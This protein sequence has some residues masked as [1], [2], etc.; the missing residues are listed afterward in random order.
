MYTSYYG[1]TKVRVHITTEL[2]KYKSTVCG[3][4]VYKAAWPWQE[5]LLLQR[6]SFHDNF[7]IA[8]YAPRTAILSVMY[9]TTE[10]SKT[11]L[12]FLQKSGSN[13]T[14]IAM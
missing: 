13:M 12:V 6:E 3:H 8:V 10:I 11:L 4:H 7:A 14:C 5:E 9:S 1:T 2:Q